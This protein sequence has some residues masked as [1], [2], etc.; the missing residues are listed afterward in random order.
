MFDIQEKIKIDAKNEHLRENFKKEL[1]FLQSC[2]DDIKIEPFEKCDNS[3]LS[4]VIPFYNSEKYLNR[5][6][7]SIQKQE[8]KE[9]E[10]LF[11]DDCSTDNGLQLL[12]EYSKIDKRIVIV[13]N[14]KNKGCLYG[15]VRCIL[16]A[17][18]DYTMIIDA[19]DMLLSNLKELYEIS[20]KNNKDINDFS[21]LRGT[22]NNFN[23]IRMRNRE[24]YQPNIGEIIFT[25]NYV[26]YT[27]IAKKNNEI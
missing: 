18:A 23:E 19:D 15:Y 1:N 25:N 22:F 17:K 10:I 11:V 6:L 8:L 3:K 24:Y 27:F 7:R 16:E 21:Y 20:E 13:K 26:G 2:L 14:D 4:L 12:E 9:I 5:L